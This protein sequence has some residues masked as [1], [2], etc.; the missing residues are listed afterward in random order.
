MCNLQLAGFPFKTSNC[1]VQQS[2]S[3]RSREEEEK[4]LIVCKYL[5]IQWTSAGSLRLSYGT[6]AFS[7]S[8]LGHWPVA[9]WVRI[10]SLAC[11]RLPFHLNFL[12]SHFIYGIWPLLSMPDSGQLWMR[13]WELWA[14]S[15]ACD[16]AVD[17]FWL[18]EGRLCAEQT[19]WKMERPFCVL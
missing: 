6:K 10:F 15:A 13:Y 7:L 16:P 14:R 2:G 4:E 9:L 5:N 3:L 18:C 19:W 1:K 17:S 11:S 8:F 12:W